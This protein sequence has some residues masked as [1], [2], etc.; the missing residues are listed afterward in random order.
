MISISGKKE[1]KNHIIQPKKTPKH[2]LLVSNKQPPDL[3]SQRGAL[4][5]LPSLIKL[6]HLSL[7]Q[8]MMC[9]A[10]VGEFG[11]SPIQYP[12]GEVEGVCG[13]PLNPATAADMEASK[14]SADVIQMWLSFPTIHLLFLSDCHLS[15]GEKL[16]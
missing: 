14:T 8:G 7:S 11:P 4:R 9:R 3:L 15:S 6:N 2:R 16:H 1:K 12:P 5:L 10:S 13:S